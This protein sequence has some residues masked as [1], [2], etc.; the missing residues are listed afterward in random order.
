M[1]SLEFCS[2]IVKWHCELNF[3]RAFTHTGVGIT[4][5]GVARAADHTNVPRSRWLVHQ[6]HWTR[7]DA[8]EIEGAINHD[9]GNIVVQCG[10]VVVFVRLPGLALEFLGTT[11]GIV[12]WLVE[13]LERAR[14]HRDL[15]VLSETTEGAFIEET[16]GGGDHR[17][18]SDDR[19]A[20]SALDVLAKVRAAKTDSDLQCEYVSA[21]VGLN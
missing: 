2:C 13:S 8:V 21:F 7:A 5:V 3:D 1:T 6:A 12:L 11:S 14:V 17:A 16:M 4:P 9:H 15:I 18:R 19:A 20:A 10:G